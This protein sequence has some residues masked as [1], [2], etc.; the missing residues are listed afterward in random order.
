MQRYYHMVMENGKKYYAFISY[1]REDEAWA[2]WLQE[3]LERYKMPANLN[4]KEKLPKEI[5]PVF[6]DKSELA[7][8]LLADE[9]RKALDE[10]KYLIVVCSPNSAKSE[11]VNKEVQAFIESG[12]IDKII[13]FI[14]EG[15]PHSSDDDTECF[16]KALRELQAE[17]ELLGV[18]INEMGRDAAAVKVVATMFGLKFDELWQR[19]EREQRKKRNRIIVACV[20]GFLI[21][22]GVA[23]WMY[24]Q[25]QQTLKA[26]WK[27]L[28][29]QSKLVA[30]KVVTLSNED[31]YLARL[32]ALEILPKDVNHP[33]DRPYTVEAE[34]ALR[35]A[36]EHNSTILRGHTNGVNSC[37]FSPDGKL[38]LS[39]SYGDGT[40]RIWD[41]ET[42]N[43][44]SRIKNDEQAYSAAFSPDGKQIISACGKTIRIWDVETGS[45]L[46]VIT[47]STDYYGD[48][49]GFSPDGKKIIFQSTKS[50]MND[51]ITIYDLESDTTIFTLTKCF[52]ANY[53]PDGECL[54]A[55][56][57]KKINGPIWNFDIE[58]KIPD[59]LLTIHEFKLIDASTGEELRTFSGQKYLVTSAAFS[60]DGKRIVSSSLDRTI[61]IWDVETGKALL[62]IKDKCPSLESASFSPDGKY[63]L[64]IFSTNATTFKLWDAVSGEEIM[65]FEGH[66][67]DVVSAAFSPDGKHIV[68]ASK[69]MSLRIWDIPTIEEFVIQDDVT[70][71][72]VS[73]N[74][75]LIAYVSTDSTI[76]I[77]NTTTLSEIQKIQA[78]ANGFFNLNPLSFSYDGKNLFYMEGT[79]NIQVQFLDIGWSVRGEK[80]SLIIWNSDT[81]ETI[82]IQTD[83]LLRVSSAVFSLNG[84]KFVTTSYHSRVRIWDVNNKEV[85]NRIECYGNSSNNA[86]FAI[87]SPDGK[88]TVVSTRE[89]RIIV[90]DTETGETIK[91]FSGHSAQVSFTNFNPQG[92]LLISASADKTLRIWDY[93]TGT[94]IKVL[95]GHTLGVNH[96]A[97]SPD[98]NLI[99]SASD[100]KTIRVWNVESG[101]C[102]HI[103]E[104]HIDAVR[105]VAFT[106]DGQHIVSYS[107][108]GTIRKWGFPPLQ[109]LIDQTRERFKDRPLTPEERHQYYLE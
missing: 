15:I 108:D 68:S 72:A 32:L 21:M 106:P 79:N 103:I 75:E 54:V 48:C 96:A 92:N 100:D 19:H 7:A 83:S 95:E 104:G 25:R 40:I 35:T 27:M 98:G 28:E 16:P 105:W 71:A 2:Q 12:R 86:V 53:S 17:N 5:R 67:N 8:G 94:C 52:F 30:E 45:E 42:G 51:Y 22:A 99:A 73:H 84:D 55:I 69:D 14:I 37:S 39:S 46:K 76:H 58:S 34:L 61:M 6:R 87:F 90:Y 43:E 74:G 31:S 49:I 64:S 29:S 109:D 81:G 91:T 60:P 77:I 1:K 93:E 78:K 59:S 23:F 20:A 85:L 26:N 24:A 82:Q 97:F 63:I 3:K 33:T 36:C 102:I 38:I 62:T 41:V 89:N 10:S 18:N 9:I 66:T 56:P 107:L 57:I 4:G 47:D 88:Q 44:I 50:Y 70:S 11:W 65:T 13:P 101:S 80:S